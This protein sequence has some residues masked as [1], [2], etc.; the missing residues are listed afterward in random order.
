MSKALILLDAQDETWLQIAESIVGDLIDQGE[1]EKNIY[2]WPIFNDLA[3]PT[4][5]YRSWILNIFNLPDPFSLEVVRARFEAMGV[6]IVMGESDIYPERFD[7]HL[8]ETAL[9]ESVDSALITLLR[10]AIPRNDRRTLR[11]QE[12]LRQSGYK[13]FF[14]ACQMIKTFGIREIYIPGWRFPHQK[15]PALA[16]AQFCLKVHFFEIGFSRK[17]YFLAE[18]PTFDRKQ[19][20]LRAE[21]V[22]K[23]MT[24]TELSQSVERWFTSRQ[25]KAADGTNAYSANWDSRLKID[26]SSSSVAVFTSSQDEFL[27]LGPD[28]MGQAW[29]DQWEFFHEVLSRYELKD[30]EIFLRVHPNIKNKSIAEYIREVERILVLSMRH[31]NLRVIWHWNPLSS[32]TLLSATGMVVVWNSTVGLEASAMGKKVISGAKSYYG[33]ISDVLQAFTP[34]SLKTSI[35]SKHQPNKIGAMRYLSYISEH[36]DRLL[37]GDLRPWDIKVAGI[38]RLIY[39]LAEI[40]GSGAFPTTFD[41]IS[42]VFWGRLQSSKA[43]TLFVVK[44]LRLKL[45]TM[46]EIGRRK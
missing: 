23:N 4:S 2:I 5:K 19:N 39:R 38:K 44:L 15:L 24:S 12:K 7:D 33:D 9:S 27:S 20:Q 10:S 45:W 28:W 31:A 42:S 21:V 8:L 26:T 32:Y 43:F 11:L 37:R 29:K 6:N 41:S 46:G 34:E 16:A 36:R 3:S 40:L 30:G 14:K 35:D 22:T 13:T 17:K 1:V 18:F 25:P